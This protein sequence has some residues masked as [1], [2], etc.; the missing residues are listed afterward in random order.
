MGASIIPPL[1]AADFVKRIAASFPNGWASQIAAQTGNLYALWE[2]TGAGAGLRDHRRAIRPGG[3]YRV[4]TAIDD[5][6]DLL[7][8]DF[9]GSGDSAIPRAPGETD[10]SFRNRLQQGLLGD[11][12]YL[13]GATRASVAYAVFK[14]TGVMPRIT[15]PWNLGDSGVM[16]NGLSPGMMY[17][18]IDNP[19]TPGRMTN[20][21]LPYQGFIDTILPSLVAPIGPVNPVPYMANDLADANTAYMW[22]GPATPS[23]T[24]FMFDLSSAIPLG[25]EAVYAAIN[26][27]RPF[28]TIA[29]VRF[30]PAALLRPPAYWDETGIACGTATNTHGLDRSA[31]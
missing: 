23:P 13:C 17:M 22:N 11:F 12:V 28:G 21:S 14:V 15:E 3:E 6:L 19:V 29:W 31:R 26:K 16:S 25:K 27:A 8:L 7:S 24:S 20:L 1:T 2:L 18:G 4:Q 9:F 10:T 30:V 5:A